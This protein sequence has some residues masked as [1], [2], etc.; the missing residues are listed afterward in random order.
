MKIVYCGF[1]NQHLFEKVGQA[2]LLKLELQTDDEN[3]GNDDDDEQDEVDNVEERSD[4]DSEQVF[5]EAL[6]NYDL[7][8]LQREQCFVEKDKITKWKKHC[9]PRN[10]R[11]RSYKNVPQSPDVKNCAKSKTSAQEIWECLFEEEML[12]MVTNC[13]NIKIE[14][15][16]LNF[17][18]DK[19]AKPTNISEIKNQICF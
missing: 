17:N 10:V 8:L 16:A 2:R 19:G 5:N 11:K 13:T 18:R 15:I 6:E 7:N 4:S 1:H 14:G 9:P 3:H 12:N